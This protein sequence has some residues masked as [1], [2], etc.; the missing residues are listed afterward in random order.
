MPSSGCLVL[1]EVKAIKKLIAQNHFIL[2]TKLYDN[3]VTYT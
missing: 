2:E 1:Y 3:H